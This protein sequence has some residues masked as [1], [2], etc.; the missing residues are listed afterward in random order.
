MYRSTHPSRLRSGGF[1]LTEMLVVIA[2][3]GIASAFTLPNL[4]PILVSNTVSG[5]VNGLMA[6]LGYARSE[7]IAR[8]VPVSVCRRAANAQGAGCGAAGGDWSN[9]LLVFVD[10]GVTGTIDGDDERLR[11]FHASATGFELRAQAGSGGAGFASMT[12]G[13]TGELVV[14]PAGGTPRFVVGSKASAES[15]QSRLV[16]VTPAGRLRVTRLAEDCAG[17]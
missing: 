17:G 3:V 9:G 7:A 11:L 14:G 1:T 15:D 6:V 16:C 8:G 13:A 5:N 4:R 12:W 10:G 2:I